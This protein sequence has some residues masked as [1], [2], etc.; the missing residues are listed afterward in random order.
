MKMIQRSI[1]VSPDMDAWVKEYAAVNGFN[2]AQA[3]RHLLIKSKE[4]NEATKTLQKIL[5]KFEE[6]K[7]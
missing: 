2:L 1:T 5:A 4:V 7:I 6:E 3:Y